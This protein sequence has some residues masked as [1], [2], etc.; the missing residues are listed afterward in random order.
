MGRREFMVKSGFL[1]FFLFNLFSFA[2]CSVIY[3]ITTTRAVSPEQTLNSPRQIFELGFFTPNNN[4][5][6]QYVGMWFKEASPQTVIWVAN[7]E[8]PITSSSA[9]LTIGSDGNLRLLDGQRNTIWS[10]NISRQSN[11]S[12]AVLSD[13][14][15]FILRNSI[16]GDDLWKSSQH[17]T[18]SLFP[19]T[20]LAYNETTGMRLALTSWK[21]NNDP[22]IGDFTAGVPPL[23]PPQAFVWK[24]SKP[25]WRSGP[26]GKTKFIGTPE[27]D[28]D[29][30]S[31]F[32]VIEGLQPGIAYLTVSVHRNCSYS[33]FVVSPAG[34]LRFLCWL[35]ERGWFVRWEAPVT[36]CEVY[37]ACGPFGVCQ[38]Y[39]PNLTCRCLKGFVPKSDDEWRKGNWTGGCI[40]RTELS[41]GGNTSSVNAQGG[42]PDGFLKVGGLKLPDWHVY[43]K[44]LDKNECHQRCL[45]NCSC[46]GYS[47]VDGIGCLVWT[48]N[49]LDM[50]ELP[51]GGQDLNLRLALT[52]LGESN[53]KLL[54]G[55][56][57]SVITVSSVILIGSMI[58]CFM[59]WRAKK[60]SKPKT[61]APSDTSRENEDS[62]ELPLFDFNNI[63]LATNNFDIENKLGQGGYGPV[64]R[65]TLDGKDVAVKRLSSSSSQGIGEFKTEMKLISK[66]QHRNLVR[67]LGCCIEREEK[68]LVYEYMP[69]KSLDTYLFDTTR[70]A[71]LDWTKRFNIIMGVARGLLYLHRDSCLRVIHRDLKVSNILLDEKMN[72]KISDFGLARIFEG[73]QDLG[74]THK[75]VGTIGYMAPEYLFGG[76]FSEKSDVFGFGILI[77]EIVSGRKT[78]S[79]QYDEQNMSLLSYAWQSWSE[80]KGVRMIDEAL[81]DSFSSTEVSRCVNI[82]L[83]CAQD[84]AADRPSMAAVVS[85]L[86]GE[87]TKLPE[88]NQPTFTFKSISTSN[89]QSQSNS[90][91]SV[92]KVTES[93]I[94][95]R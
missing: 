48:T 77:L 16:T 45:S 28:A 7:R 67:L 3:N 39:A 84:H 52:E 87:K 20:W 90:T 50:H 73:T 17:P 30:K 18:D 14:G 9:S 57:V 58:C 31:G 42:K 44:V 6:N 8:N 1:C 86:S 93:I 63:M 80:S 21:S 66:L 75:V 40:R 62:I 85:M 64:Y 2:Y 43:L 88:P 46:S 79:F 82:G 35:K 49:L 69:N 32:T 70:K 37:G 56:I 4:S 65:G 15:N 78:S 71:E 55:I 41:C 27:M 95:P 12:I 29:Y 13:D 11:S 47:Y 74:S 94:E 76:I 10:T 26:W 5:R 34:V 33:M 61:N 59:R 51:F 25:H 92:N 54:I 23:T 24:G 53:Y 83:L 81:M 38:R 60:R 91:P 22:S 68:I 36:P 72:P 89:F 19:G